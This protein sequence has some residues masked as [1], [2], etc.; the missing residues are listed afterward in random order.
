MRRTPAQPFLTTQRI[1]AFS[2]G[3]FAIAI[4][5]LV[6]EI[7]VPHLDG[8]DGESLSAAL[9]RLWPSYF[10]YVFSFVMIGIYWANHHYIFHLYKQ[11]DHF[12]SLL[13]VFFLM[14]ISFLP[15]PT[16]V[17]AEY[18]T[19]ATHRQ[20]A[21][22]FYTFGLFLPALGW[23]LVWLYGSQ[24]RLID[25]RLDPDFCAYLTRQYAISNVFYLAAPL[26]S[27]WNGNAGLALCIGFTLLYLLPPK[28]PVYQE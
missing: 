11:S 16:A 13:N 17:L 3:V 18:I 25:Q 4:T 12:F 21:I 8:A 9:L 1:E 20:D 10:G 7:K 19:D 22:T 2:D 15:F 6:L 26:L 5:L 27:I 28:Q 24:R 14:C 23:F